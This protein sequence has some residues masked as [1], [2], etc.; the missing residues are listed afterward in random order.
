VRVFVAGAGGMV[1]RAVSLHCKAR[2]DQVVA[3]DHS[4]LDIADRANVMAALNENKPDVV[5]NCAAW[6][7]V[8]ECERDPKRAYS[9]NALGPENLALASR[10]VNAGFLTISTDYVFDGSKQ[11]FYTQRDDPNPQSVYAVAK[12]DGERRAHDTYA[13][14]II[15]RSGFIFGP[16][17]KNFLSAIVQK[18]EENEPI[19]AISDSFGTPTFVLDLAQRLRELAEL[20]LPGVFHIANAG[21]GASYEE[22][23]RTVVQAT[24][25]NAVIQPV[26]DASLQRPA[27]RPAN[28]RLKCLYSEALGLSP[29]RPWRGALAHFIE[30]Q[31]AS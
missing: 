14:T 1:G 20:D 29:L 17:G 18:V 26:T 21:D 15:V 24:G 12:L 5:I 31:H 28:S 25:Q 22:F 23:A 30:I 7:D 11:G 10:S 19:K 13:R 9:A 3:A 4:S 16:G 2:G 6:T 27:R 8:D